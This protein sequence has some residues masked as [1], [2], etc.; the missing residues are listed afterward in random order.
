MG[1]RSQR[2]IIVLYKSGGAFLCK[3]AAGGVCSHWPAA[4][5]QVSLRCAF[6]NVSASASRDDRVSWSN[7]SDRAF[8]RSVC[9]GA[10]VTWEFK[11]TLPLKVV[12]ASKEAEPGVEESH[13]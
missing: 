7:E 8:C 6:F 11:S 12:M 2:W 5:A 9:S 1:H 13:M 10:K 4:G 3:L